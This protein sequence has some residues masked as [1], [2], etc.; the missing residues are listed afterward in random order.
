MAEAL[1]GP[2][3]CS[4]CGT[5]LIQGATFCS[6][7]G[8]P[9]G[10][11][12]PQTFSAPSVPVGGPVNVGFAG[13]GLQALGYGLWAGILMIL[14]IPYG[15]GV[16]ILSGWYVRSLTFSDGRTA[17]FN[18]RGSQIWF[19]IFLFILSSLL[20]VIPVI[21]GIIGWLVSTRL[22][23]GLVR[24]FFS[25]VRLSTGHTL[26]FDGS[27]WPFAGWYIL[28]TVS[29]ITIIGWAWVASA[30]MRWVCR[31]VNMGQEHLEFVG[32]GIDF[33]WRGIVVLIGSILIIT[34]PWLFVWYL[35]W[36]TSNIMIRPGRPLQS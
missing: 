1:G 15:W 7:C 21:G 23:L 29:F 6:S 28:W 31:N 20:N 8:A 18:G 16:S 11:P 5:Q 17:T 4:S 14:I 30:G 27:Y 34:I 36:I 25:N 12:A 35:R 24:W 3:Y 2:G 32:S 22:Q 9:I 10:G 13:T 19:Y 33:L 26:R